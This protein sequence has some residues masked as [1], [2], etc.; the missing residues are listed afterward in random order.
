MEAAYLTQDAYAKTL[1]GLI[2]QYISRKDP[3]HAEDWDNALWGILAYLR[4]ELGE[5][6]CGNPRCLSFDNF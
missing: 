6:F 1:E 5:E 4:P 3:T 2:R